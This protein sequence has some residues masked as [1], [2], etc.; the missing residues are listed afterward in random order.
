MASRTLYRWRLTK[1]TP[2]ATSMPVCRWLA[3]GV[4]L[5]LELLA[6][7]RWTRPLVV[8]LVLEMHVGCA[9]ASVWY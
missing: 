7:Q 5:C 6:P 2:R 1:S 3:R 4:K 8:V 9:T